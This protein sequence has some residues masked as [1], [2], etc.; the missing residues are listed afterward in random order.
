[1]TTSARWPIQAVR[2]TLHAGTSASADAYVAEFDPTGALIYSN[3][4]GDHWSERGDG[5]AVDASG[6]PY[7]IAFRSTPGFEIGYN[8]TTFVTRA[9][10][11]GTIDMGP[12]TTATVLGIP[13]RAIAIGPDGSVI[14]VMIAIS[15]DLPVGNALQSTMKAAPT[16]TW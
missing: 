11:S 13:S 4:I 2:F 8:G 15:P 5:I 9:D 6:T 12:S 7:I 16:C 14:A 1:M 10:G 3:F